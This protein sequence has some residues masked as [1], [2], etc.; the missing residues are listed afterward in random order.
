MEK[1][2]TVL[3]QEQRRLNAGLPGLQPG[4]SI[5]QRLFPPLGTR[6]GFTHRQPIAWA[7]PDGSLGVV[8][9]NLPDVSADFPLAVGDDTLNCAIL[10]PSIQTY[11][12]A[13]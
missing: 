4:S 2:G 5:I 13:S 3:R 8:L 7:N 1:S 10:A 11:A 12:R 6:R 9:I